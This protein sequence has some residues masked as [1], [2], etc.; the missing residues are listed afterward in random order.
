M[1]AV[2]ND[3]AIRLLVARSARQHRSG[4]RF[5][6]VTPLRYILPAAALERAAPAPFRGWETP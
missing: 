2:P 5:G 6:G 1:T 3:H 4:G